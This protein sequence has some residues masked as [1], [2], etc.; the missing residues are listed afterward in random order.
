[1]FESSVGWGDVR[2]AFHMQ[3]EANYILA[4]RNPEITPSESTGL[5]QATNVE[6]PEV[7]QQRFRHRGFCEA[8]PPEFL[9]YQGA[10]FL[11]VDPLAQIAS[12]LGI[13]IDTAQ[14]AQAAADIFRNLRL[15]AL[16]HPVLE[17]LFNEP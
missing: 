14:E 8:D 13:E 12:E 4:V 2:T 3:Q 1:M 16:Q 11:L 15:E 10:Q 9:D 7:L 5:A 6:Y 17:S